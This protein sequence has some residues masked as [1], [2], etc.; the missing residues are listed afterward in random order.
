MLVDIRGGLHRIQDGLDG[1]Q[2]IVRPVIDRTDDEL[3]FGGYLQVPRAEMRC[4]P[5]DHAA[6]HPLAPNHLGQRLF[7][8]PI[9]Q[10][11]QDGFR[12]KKR[13]QIPRRRD[14]VVSLGGQKEDID[15]LG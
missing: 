11:Y 8:D 2:A 4:P 5:T 6:D 9:L 1:G 3:S 15:P 14:T 7:T 13:Q 12:F 10:G